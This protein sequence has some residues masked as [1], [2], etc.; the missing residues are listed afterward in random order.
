[1]W[2]RKRQLNNIE[3]AVKFE[4]VSSTYEHQEWV[5]STYEHQK[6]LKVKVQ[7]TAK[8]WSSYDQLSRVYQ[9]VKMKLIYP[10]ARKVSRTALRTNKYVGILEKEIRKQFAE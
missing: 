2:K 3:K 6:Y 1:M 4:W 8:L 9:K 10:N 5:S 7:T